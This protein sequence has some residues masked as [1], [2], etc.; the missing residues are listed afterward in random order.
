MLR[1]H[2][3][4]IIYSISAEEAQDQVVQTNKG[5]SEEGA[6]HKVNEDIFTFSFGFDHHEF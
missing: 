2:G 3:N 4:E 6:S 1:P 5:S